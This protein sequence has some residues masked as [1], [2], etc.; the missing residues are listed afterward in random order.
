VTTFVDTSALYA[1]LDEDDANHRLAAEGFRSLRG[2]DLVTH[3]YVIVE[4]LALVGRRLPWPAS[5]RLLDVF[6]PLIDV[7][8]VDDALH[9]AAVVA[10][11]EAGAA[12]VSFVDR[13]SFGFM[14]A[15]GVPRAFA[16]DDDFPKNGFGLVS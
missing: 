9:R 5:A 4:T 12:S 2:G 3:T 16:F 7:R 15:H 14:R 11:R 10:Y 8:P 6:L 13:T 1:L